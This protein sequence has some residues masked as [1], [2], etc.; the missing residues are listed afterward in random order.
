MTRNLVIVSAGTSQPS[1]TRMLADR[2]AAGS[3]ERLHEMELTATV[4][5]VE[6]A[7]LAVDVARASV[8]GVPSAELHAAIEQIAAADAV[9]AAAP[10]YKAG[11]S[12][13]FK[14]FADLQAT[15]RAYLQRHN[16]D[17]P[18]SPGQNSPKLSPPSSD[19][20]LYLPS[21]Q[22][23]YS[24]N[25][26]RAINPRHNPTQDTLNRLLKPFKLRLSL[27]PLTSKARRSAA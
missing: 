13:L 19:A 21:E 5:A 18:C 9:I 12:G 8:T 2:I 20:S 25:V 6:V 10:V 14:S 1:T 22:V 7:P 24:P 15:I 27:A 26:L 23:H 4:G 16:T 11:I 3:L 17:P